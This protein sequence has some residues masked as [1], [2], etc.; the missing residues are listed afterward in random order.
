[1]RLFHTKPKYRNRKYIV[2]NIDNN[3]VVYLTM[4]SRVSAVSILS[5]YGLDWVNEVRS[6]AEVKGFFL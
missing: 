6:P 5:G 3:N 4:R 2:P 1:V